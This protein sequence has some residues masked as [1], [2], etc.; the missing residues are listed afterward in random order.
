VGPERIVK[1]LKE[2]LLPYHLD[3]FKQ[4]AGRLALEHVDEMN[5][6]VKLLSSE[7]E[8]VAEALQ[9]LPVKQWESGANF[10]LFKPVEKV[11]ISGQKLWELLLERSI[12]VRNCSSWPRLENCLRVT[13]GTLEE[14][15]MFLNA[16][17]GI[18]E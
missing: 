16:L 8:R 14:N 1:A 12:L 4:I 3:A 10:I 6:R 15:N 5:S 2:I 9:Q 7:R 17:K 11:G 18:L 13:I